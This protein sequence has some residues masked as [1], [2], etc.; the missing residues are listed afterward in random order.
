MPVKKETNTTLALW[1]VSEIELEALSND[2]IIL[3]ME[4]PLL[5]VEF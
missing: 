3:V 2:A 4:I 1:E 5:N